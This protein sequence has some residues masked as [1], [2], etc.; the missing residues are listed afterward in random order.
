MPSPKLG[1]GGRGPRERPALELSPRP[2]ALSPGFLPSTW[3]SMQPRHPDHRVS[4]PC[5][6]PCWSPPGLG[7]T[8]TPTSGRGVRQQ[9]GPPHLRASQ[10]P[11]STEVKTAE[12]KDV[13]P[14]S[15]ARPPKSQLAA[16]QPRGG[17]WNLR[18]TDTAYPRQRRSR[19]RRLGG[20]QNVK[21]KLTIPG[22][23]EAATPVL[24]GLGLK[25]RW[26]GRDP[27]Q[28][29]PRA[30]G[31]G[32]PRWTP[33]QGLALASLRAPLTGGSLR[34]GGAYQAVPWAGGQRPPRL[35]LE[36]SREAAGPQAE[37]DGTGGCAG[38]SLLGSVLH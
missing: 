8:L 30:E 16:E 9:P 26:G 23:L 22:P 18:N 14:A 17:C 34:A 27:G 28:D 36:R 1:G 31:S 29:R 19:N 15:P 21:I 2:E 32:P 12:K 33:P 24:L 37:E 3:G 20:A 13:H 35:P 6:C 38:A 25:D 11:S 10:H 7:R 5:N 4:S